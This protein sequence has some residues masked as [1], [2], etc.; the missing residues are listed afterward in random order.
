MNKAQWLNSAETIGIHIARSAIWDG[1]YCNW[2]SWHTL[3]GLQPTAQYR[4]Q[5]L[6]PSVYDGTAGLA[7][8]LG[9]LSRAT[10]N[11]LFKK[12]ALGA[13]EHALQHADDGRQTYSLGFFSGSLGIAIAAI[14]L[15]IQ[16]SAAPIAEAGIN[17]LSRFSHAPSL[18]YED[19]VIAGIAGAIPCFIGLSQHPPAG[20]VL[21]WL[22]DVIDQQIGKL[23]EHS[24]CNQQPHTGR[25]MRFWPSQPFSPNGLTG[26]S[27]GNAGIVNALLEWHRW[28]GDKTHAEAVQ[29]GLC[30]ERT[31][32]SQPNQN[33]RDLRKFDLVEGSAASSTTANSDPAPSSDVYS[34]AWCH[35]A[36]GIGLGRLRTIELL[37]DD[38]DILIELKQAVQTTRASL[39]VP[40]EHWPNYSLCH[41]AFGNAELLVA[42]KE[43]ALALDVNDAS[44]DEQFAQ[45]LERQRY[46]HL[47]WKCG[48]QDG[49]TTPGLMLGTAGIGAALLRRASPHEFPLPMLLTPELCQFES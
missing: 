25:T 14:K 1:K 22:A 27:H 29:E 3:P 39:E 28:R 30:F 34:L 33:W 32:F 5:A 6:G 38:A 16:L 11:S 20:R 2:M 4:W 43:S 15:G 47:P 46:P 17:V 44:I 19:D 13:I 10:E 31:N 48:T 18:D 36:P 24:R 41:G 9:D 37:R 40:V 45:V 12:T 49:R 26:Y 23:M 7:W 42:A 35:G 8:F 21:P